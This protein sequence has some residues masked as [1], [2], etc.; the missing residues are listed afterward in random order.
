VLDADVVRA[1]ASA[2]LDWFA[3]HPEAPLAAELWCTG[4]PAWQALAGAATRTP[5]GTRIVADIGYDA[6]PYGVGYLVS[7]WSLAPNPSSRESERLRP[8]EGAQ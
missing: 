2:D 7:T 5:A 8:R 1:L 4:G 3:T 6:A